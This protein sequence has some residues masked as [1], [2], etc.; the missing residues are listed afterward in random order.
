[1][2]VE[3][4]GLESFLGRGTDDQSG[5]LSTAVADVSF[6]PFIESDDQQ[7]LTLKRGAGN[8]RR[9][10]GLQPCISLCEAAIVSVVQ[11]VGRDKRIL[12]QRVAGDIGRE[13][14]KG[15]YIGR[16]GAIALNV[17]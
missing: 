5:D 12:R 14:R 9:D 2:L 15:H 3:R 7:A 6:I 16:L 13:L 4:L 10:V 1:M 11:K 17:R 8:Q